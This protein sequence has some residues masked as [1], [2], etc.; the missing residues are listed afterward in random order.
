M[1]ISVDIG[2]PEG[3]TADILIREGD[4]P[5]YVALTFAHRHGITSEALIDLLAE[6]IQ[7]N[8]EAVLKEEQDI[9]SS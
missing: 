4:D 8:V 3:E 5:K 6:Q 7:S 1:T 9:L 2:N